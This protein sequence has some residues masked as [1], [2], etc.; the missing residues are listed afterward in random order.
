VSPEYV[1]NALA[2]S[3]GGFALGYT[4]AAATR[5]LH[6]IKEAVVPEE[7]PRHAPLRPFIA[8]RALGVLL[9]VMALITVVAVALATQRRSDISECQAEVNRDLITALAARSKIADNDRAALDA[10][11]L[12]IVSNQDLPE[13]KRQRLGREA[14]DNYVATIAESKEA[15]AKVDMP[16]PDDYECGG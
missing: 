12:A 16:Q 4:F 6:S 2:W 14:I 10:L 11:I 9:V 3:L 5:D 15:R 13:R 7:T 8:N 1:L